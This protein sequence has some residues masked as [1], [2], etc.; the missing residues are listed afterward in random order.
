MVRVEDSVVMNFKVDGLGFRRFKEVVG[1]YQRWFVYD[2]GSSEV[3]GLAPL[4]AEYDESGNL[5]AK[6]HYDGGGLIAMTRNNQSYWYG[7]EGIGTVR[8]LMGSQGQV[9]DAYAFDAWGNELISPQSQVQN[10]FKYVGKYGYYWDT[11]SALMLLGVRYYEANLGRFVSLDPVTS[12]LNWYRYVANP[13]KGID[14][15]GLQVGYCPKCGG[16]TY[17]GY[18]PNCT[19]PVPKPP[20]PQPKPPRQPWGYGNF[21]GPYRGKFLNEEEARKHLPDQQKCRQVMQ[22]PPG[23]GPID[24]LDKCCMEHD[25]CYR[26]LDPRPSTWEIVRV[27][28]CRVPWN[29]RTGPCDAEL[30]RCAIQ[31]VDCSKSPNPREC[32]FWRIGIIAIFCRV[33]ELFLHSFFNRQNLTIYEILFIGRN[34]HYVYKN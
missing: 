18:C 23:G 26:C 12:G 1:Q 22:P 2:M 27:I 32:S 31:D 33:Y 4:V 13:V 19:P 8:Q 15:S 29:R 25:K 11:E 6:Y 28:I 24:S 5:V 3:P 30:C 10:P 16:I 9:V 17:G 7:F 21:C 14:P 34:D 20:Y